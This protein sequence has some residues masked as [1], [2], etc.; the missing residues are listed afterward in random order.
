M[1]CLLLISVK[2]VW[3]GTALFNRQTYIF[4]TYLSFNHVFEEKAA[5][6]NE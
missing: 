1:D 2:A 4:K 5:L 6:L 3:G